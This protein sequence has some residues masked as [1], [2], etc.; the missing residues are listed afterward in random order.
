MGIDEEIRQLYGKGNQMS[1]LDS[2]A[3]RAWAYGQ[4]QT[5]EEVVT[6]RG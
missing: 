3:F 6:E 1:C 2:E 4:R 5:D